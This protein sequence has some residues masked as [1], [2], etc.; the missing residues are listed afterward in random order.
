M[1]MDKNVI[2]AKKYGR[3]IYEIALE[4]KSLEKTEEELKLIRDSIVEHDE[5]KSFLNHPFLTKDAKKDTIQKLFADKVQPVVLQFC[6]V[7]IDRDR[8]ELFPEMVDVYTVLA[9]EGMG[10]EEALVT[11]AFPMTG[12]Q[13]DALKAKLE[14]MTGKKIIMKQ[15]VDAALLGGFT[16]Q[17]G[18][19]LIDGSVARQLQTLKALIGNE[20][21][22]R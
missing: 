1:I 14:E 3:A 20:N 17:I 4:Q 6:C 22:F 21:Q 11:S 7:V 2:V 5:L 8:F 13:A 18:D 9:H 16:V 19:Q 10:I 12:A 15:K